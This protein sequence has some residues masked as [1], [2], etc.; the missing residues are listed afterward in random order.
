MALLSSRLKNTA[1][2]RSVEANG[3]QAIGKGEPDKEAVALLQSCMEEL[4]FKSVR[5]KTKPNGRLDGIF[6][7]ETKE[8]IKKFQ[9]RQG[10]IPDGLVGPKTLGELDAIYVAFQNTDAARL[11]IELRSPGR[12]WEMT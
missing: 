9:R 4:G 2:L 3:K 12:R 6:G 11:A 7:E 1:R 5:S 8:I 10:L